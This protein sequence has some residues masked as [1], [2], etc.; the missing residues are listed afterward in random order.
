MRFFFFVLY[1]LFF[2]DNFANCSPFSLNQ[3][4]ITAELSSAA[5]CDKENYNLIKWREP[6]K[7]FQVTDIIHDIETDLNGYIGILPSTKTIYI[8]FRGSQ[9]I[10]NW[11]EDFEVKKVDYLTFPE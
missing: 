2:Y 8:V 10:R 11:I 5:Y 9:S 4:N 7:G 6:A 3:A 1:I